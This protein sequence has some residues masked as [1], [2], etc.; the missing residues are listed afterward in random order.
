[1]AK[2]I[3]QGPKEEV[4]KAKTVLKQTF[5]VTSDVVNTR[6]EEEH[7]A[8]IDV[9]ATAF[10]KEKWSDEEI[11]K[12]LWCCAKKERDCKSCPFVKQENCAQ[13]LKIEASLWINRLYQKRLAEEKAEKEKLSK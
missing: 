9:Y 1:M 8:I 2:I 4:Q 6:T 3:I 10:G 12:A 7:I 5:D 11:D 13:E